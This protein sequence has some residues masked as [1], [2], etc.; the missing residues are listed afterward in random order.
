MLEKIQIY[1]L[2]I[3]YF[4]QGDT[5]EFAVEYATGLVKGW[6]K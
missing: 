1:M 5:W 4:I 6:K 2:A 3:K